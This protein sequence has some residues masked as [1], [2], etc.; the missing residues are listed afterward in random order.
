MGQFLR[1]VWSI[2]QG[3]QRFMVGDYMTLV[4]VQVLAEVL[5]CPHNGECLQLSDPI[6]VLSRLK[7]TACKGNG[8][9]AIIL[10]G[11]R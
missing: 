6:V 4:T 10:L 8:S 5:H 3:L 9:A 7:G 11:L 1:G 2:Q